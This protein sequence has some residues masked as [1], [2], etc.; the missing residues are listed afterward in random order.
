MST[1]LL[2][3]DEELAVPYSNAEEPFVAMCCCSGITTYSAIKKIGKIGDDES[4]LFIGAGGLGLMAVQLFKI[5]Y[6]N[7]KGPA[8]ADIDDAKLEAAKNSGASETFNMKKDLRN[9]QRK[10]K[11]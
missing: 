9:L 6:P 11:S 2:L 8:V 1:H 4:V 7:H 10:M 5:L 3:P